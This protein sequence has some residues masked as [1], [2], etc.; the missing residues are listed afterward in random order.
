MKE[1]SHIQ[2]H[3]RVLIDRYLLFSICPT[4]KLSRTTL[5]TYIPITFIMHGKYL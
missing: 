5:Y 2:S 3:N 4:V 1:I